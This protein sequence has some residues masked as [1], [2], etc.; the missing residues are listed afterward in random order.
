MP[1]SVQH[2]QIFIC[3]RYLIVSELSCTLSVRN[4]DDICIVL[5][6]TAALHGLITSSL[7][8]LVLWHLSLEDRVIEHSVGAT[9]FV[10]FL[11]G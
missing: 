2:H 6:T 11:D 8:I 1:A 10:D 7:D 3:V 9:L 5:S 4:L